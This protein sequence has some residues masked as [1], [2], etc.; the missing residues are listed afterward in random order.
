MDE[1]AVTV[2]RVVLPREQHGKEHEESE[3]VHARER[4]ERIPG[5]GGQDLRE[6][7]DPGEHEPVPQD[8]GGKEQEGEEREEKIEKPEAGRPVRG[9]L[10]HAEAPEEE[11]E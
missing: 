9:R 2:T 11:G 6:E 7:P 8:R 3:A 4:V 5:K 1:G 10:P